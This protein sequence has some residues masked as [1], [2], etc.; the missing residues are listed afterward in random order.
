M[1]EQEDIRWLQRLENYQK[2]FDSLTSDV[3]LATQRDL[4]DIEK[5]G[6]IQ[7]FEYTYELAWNVIKDFYQAV[8][9]TNIHGSRDAFRTA[10]N[11]GLVKNDVLIKTIKSRQLTVH[12]YNE[13]AA[14]EIFHDVVNEYYDA[15]KELLDRLHQQKQ[16]RNL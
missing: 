4:T 10:F 1:S 6:L 15:F 5:R 8:G 11:K 13:K 2:A 7:A 9:E 3:E 14:S 12:T 16:L